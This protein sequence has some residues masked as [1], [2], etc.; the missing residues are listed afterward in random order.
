MPSIKEYDNKLRSLRNTSKITRTMKM[1]AVSKL[2]K[3]QDAEREAR[4]YAE[5]LLQFIS[6]LSASVE[7]ASHPLL[8]PRESARRILLLLYTS[9]RGLCGGFNNNLIRMVTGWIREQEGKVDHIGLS[10]CGRRGHSHF[11]KRFPVEDYFEDVTAEPDFHQAV[12]IADALGNHFISGNYDKVYLVYNRFKSALSQV[13]TL[14]QVLPFTSTE[15]LVG[16]EAIPQDYL[17]EPAYETLLGE[18]LPK[19]LSFKVFY[20][21]LEN[22][23]GEHGARMTAMDAAT[24]NARNMIEEY[25]LRRNRAR[26]AAITTELTEIVAGAE[27]L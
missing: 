24:N 12:H 25:T 18:L 16:G 15:F 6:R 20:A 22:S 3:A 17:F 7:A 19:T 23:A 14:E 27:A 1:V 11:T 5:R 10:F 13:P 2:R 4:H 21:L 9:D 26:Q 8:E